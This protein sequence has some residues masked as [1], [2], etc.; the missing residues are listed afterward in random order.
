MRCV[1]RRALRVGQA[2]L[3]LEEIGLPARADRLAVGLDIRLDAL[4]D[5]SLRLF[6]VSFQRPRELDLVVLQPAVKDLFE[7]GPVDVRAE[8]LGQRPQALLHF[9]K[10]EL[11][12][13]SIRGCG[14]MLTV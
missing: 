10:P 11:G 3:L 7:Q 8:P 6:E 2:L 9:S 14:G 5:L 4:L 1:R 12:L 13:L